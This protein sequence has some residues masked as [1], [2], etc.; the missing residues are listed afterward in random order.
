MLM[1]SGLACSVL[2]DC[3]DKV[4]NR[5]SGVHGHKHQI[6]LALSSWMGLT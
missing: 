6:G 3:F 5:V 4:A 2:S 1:S